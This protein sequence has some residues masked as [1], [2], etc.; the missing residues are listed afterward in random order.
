MRGATLP[1]LLLTLIVMGVGVAVA[2][3]PVGRLVDRALVRGSV[4]RFA[5]VHETT[6]QLALARGGASRLVLDTAQGEAVIQVR[7]G[8]AWEPAARFPLGGAR[9]SASQASLVFN[10]WGLGSG[11]SN[12]TIVFQRGLAA[13]TVTVSRTGRLKR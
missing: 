5:A 11:L 3:P 1:E 7:T 8:G 12:A 13:E 10:Q 6:R 2:V 9:V 4:K